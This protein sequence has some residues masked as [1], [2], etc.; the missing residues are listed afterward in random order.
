MKV[1]S[2]VDIA[3]DILEAAKNGAIKT[4]IMY[5]SRTSMKQLNPYLHMLIEGGLLEHVPEEKIY[6]TTERGTRFLESY[7]KAWRILISKRKGLFREETVQIL[8][9]G[10]SSSRR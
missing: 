10:E 6:R 7:E 5:S 3:A 2:R 4:R 9:K 1:S 8:S